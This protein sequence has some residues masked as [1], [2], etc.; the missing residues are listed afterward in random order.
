MTDL[1]S[2]LDG[3]ALRG[4]GERCPA[5]GLPPTRFPSG[6]AGEEVVRDERADRQR[7]TRELHDVRPVATDDLD[8][9]GRHGNEVREEHGVLRAE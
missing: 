7:S 9:E 3:A 6:T 4:F 2:P 5:R 1:H 8:R